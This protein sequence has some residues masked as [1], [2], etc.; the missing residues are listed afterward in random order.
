MD[1]LRH[2]LKLSA[3]LIADYREALPAL[4]VGPTAGRAQVRESLGTLPDHGESLETVLE[5]LVSAARPGLMSS[6]GPR[7][8]GFVVGGSLDAALVA[9][10]VA[11][12]W[13]QVAFNE[14]TSPAALAFEDVAGMWLKDLL[15]IPPSASVGFVTGAQAANTVGL[16][17]GRWRVLHDHGWDVGRDGLNG[18]PPV[19]VVAGAERHATI[20][21]TLRLLG[22]GESSLVVIPARPDGAMDSSALARAL[23]SAPGD[24]TIICAQAGNVNTGAFDDLASIAETA[25]AVGAWLHVDG[26]F[27][28]WAAASPN[29]D[30][31]TTGIELADS[32]AC[33]GH[34]WLN[35]PYDS[36]Y[37]FCADP[38][39]HATSMAY[40][41]DYLTGQ[42][43][44]R[45]FGGG[46]FVPESSRRARGFATWAALRS[47]GRDGVAD[48]VDRCC[49]LARHLAEG[50]GNV[51]G[52]EVVNDVVLNQ[53]LV[54]V[55]DADLTDRVERRIQAE[56]ECWLGATTWRGERLLRISVSNWS[57]TPAD[58]DRCIDA[59]G[60]ARA[61]VVA[62]P[63]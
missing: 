24:P 50:L 36:G 37:A 23:G 4:R 57:T 61:E 30:H 18:A 42:V 35:V 39:V 25:R 31:L 6:A 8:F 56:G 45:E 26:A 43:A 44:G 63:P 53:V 22:L 5:E 29:T 40:T 48:L 17:A 47:L 7:Y 54:R 38:D 62:G 16:A 14:A 10:L 58:I 33:D 12:G 32:W 1:D 11:T 9:D 46:D 28:L 51:D 27:G 21:R 59:I 19:R 3:D 49:G 60:R 15:H 34:K 2:V 20:D 52:I 13:D 55:G 41:A